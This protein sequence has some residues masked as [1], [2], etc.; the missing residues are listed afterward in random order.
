MPIELSERFIAINPNNL[1]LKKITNEMHIANI[2]E[3][4]EGVDI[5][6]NQWKIIEQKGNNSVGG[7]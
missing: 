2:P 7:R 4:P 5:K 1:I 6:Q 3:I